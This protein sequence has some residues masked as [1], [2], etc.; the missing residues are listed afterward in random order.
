MN[1]QFECLGIAVNPVLQDQIRGFLKP[2]SI[3][4][5]NKKDVK[6][7]LSVLYYALFFKSN[8]VLVY[9]SSI[10]NILLVL[11]LKLRRKK[12]IFQLHDPLPH[13][14][15]LNPLVFFVNFILCL[16]SK[17]IIVFS[18]KLKNQVKKYY[19]TQNC[20]IVSHGSVRFNYNKN[21]FDSKQIV[22]G[23]FGRNMPYKNYQK[24]ISFIESRPDVFFITVGQG[25]PKINFNN[26]KLFSG[27]IE[28]D[29]Y[30]SLMADVDYV[31]FSHKKI[32]YS[33]LLNDIISLNKVVLVNE[34]NNRNIDYD[35][36]HNIKNKN[37]VKHPYYLDVV[38]NGWDKYKHEIEQIIKN[39]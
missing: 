6:K 3:L 26:H 10:F 5:S 7:S 4:C 35:M 1:N 19:F 36:K 14:G 8:Y 16:L 27:V 28:R 21:D 15:I 2:T 24:F 38:S 13:S 11:I 18:D 31:F 32:S 29:L 17:D 22:V 12:I 39:T 37:L 20:Y 34:E 25:Y 23:F 9:N 33:G 30:F